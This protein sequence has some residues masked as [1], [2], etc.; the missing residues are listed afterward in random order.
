MPLEPV[1][2]DEPGAPRP[3]RRSLLQASALA[4]LGAL[5]ISAIGRGQAATSRPVTQPASQPTSQPA[6]ELPVPWWLGPEYPRSRVV[7]AVSPFVLTDALVDEV[8]LYEMLGMAVQVL[9]QT[10]PPADAWRRI[11]GKADRILLKFNAVGARVL[12]TNEP[13]ARVLVRMLEEAGYERKAITVAE[14]PPHVTEQLGCRRP[15]RKWG[16]AVR[17]GTGSEDLAGYLYDCDALVNV[18]LLKTHQIAG[19]SGAMKNLSHALI[20]HPARYHDNACSPYVCQVV[21]NKEVASRLRLNIT[22]AL[23]TVIR[24]GPDATAEDVFE[25]GGLLLGCDPV[26]VDAT[27]YDLLIAQRQRKGVGGRIRVPYLTA[28]AD[29]GVGR[30][31]LHELDRIPVQHAG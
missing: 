16:A 22:N 18:G 23:R 13:L 7:E 14:L 21:G 17:V 29:L 3:T 6:V 15:T 24:N 9:A 12:Q 10:E 25:F 4:A 20:R 28:G 8:A 2:P 30:R 19:M 11:I 31:A 1:K 5:P 27:G 26:A